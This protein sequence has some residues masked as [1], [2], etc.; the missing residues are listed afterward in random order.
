MEALKTYGNLADVRLRGEGCEKC[1]YDSIKDR[2]A[3][4]EVIATDQR[5]MIDFVDHGADVARRNFRSRSD[6]DNSI[7]HTAM[8]M[9]LAG[10][11]DPRDVGDNVDVVVPFEQVNE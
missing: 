9:V 2:R 11:L 10:E 1:Q 7:L 8:Q 5:L 3:V 4:A 6:T